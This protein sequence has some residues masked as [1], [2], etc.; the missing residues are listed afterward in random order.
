MEIVCPNIDP[1]I[2]LIDLQEGTCLPFGSSSGL[3]ELELEVLQ[4]YVNENL[5]KGFMQP[6]KFPI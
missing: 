4:T 1:M 5:K 6:S 2:N 3:F